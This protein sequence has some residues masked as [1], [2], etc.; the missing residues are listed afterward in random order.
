MLLLHLIKD[1]DLDHPD[2]ANRFSNES[3]SNHLHIILAAKS[4]NSKKILALINYN[5]KILSRGIILII[6][7]ILFL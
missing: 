6:F 7:L 5:E 3:S 1:F 4:H 2:A